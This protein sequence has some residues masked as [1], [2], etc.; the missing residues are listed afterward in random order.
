MN[1]FEWIQIGLFIA[2]LAL[3]TKP[4][5]IY[6]FRVLDP[7][8]KTFLDPVLVP[9]RD[10]FIE[11]WAWIPGRSSMEAVRR[12]AAL[13]QPGRDAFHLCHSAS[14]APPSR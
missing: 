5:G 10:L 1:T 12:L 7:E 13:L 2:L 8:G 4:I 11:S 6:L 3:L 14:P 9:W